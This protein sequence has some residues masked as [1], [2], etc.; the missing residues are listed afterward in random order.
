MTPARIVQLLR[1]GSAAMREEADRLGFRINIVGPAVDGM[2]LD[3]I[4]KMWEADN[5]L[6]E[7]VDT[8]SIHAYSRFST[9]QCN[10]TNKRCIRR[11]QLI[12]DFL[13]SHGGEHVHLASTEG[14]IAGTQGTCRG[15]QVHT[16][17]GQ[18]A[19]NEEALEWI[20]ANP[21]L[22]FDFWVTYHA[23]DG[24]RPYGYPC[25]AGVYDNAF[26]KSRLG[27][28]RADLSMKP[29]GARYRQLAASW[30]PDDPPA[31]DPPVE[32]PPVEDPPVEDPPVEDPPV[33]DPPD[34]TVGPVIDRT[35]G[36]HF[37]NHTGGARV[38][39]IFNGLTSQIG[40][41]SAQKNYS[42][43][44]YA[45][46]DLASPSTIALAIVYGPND[47]G[48]VSNDNRTTVMLQL[49]ASDGAPPATDM[50]ARTQGVAL[51]EVSFTDTADESVG[52]EIAS[53]DAVNEYDNVWVVMTTGSNKG[54]RM[55]EIEFRRW[56]E[57]AGAQATARRP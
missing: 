26:W 54:H 40:G 4:V 50:E 19:L 55:T 5:R 13:D 39:G 32:D 47:I 27:V 56:T 21:G 6:F 16:E 44:S 51:G 10:V 35:L 15:P 28:V 43:M 38:A 33:D 3:Y 12:R 52:R 30:Y 17:E 36:T 7:Y 2:D 24:T 45:G 1:I 29:W 42:T 41:Q 49:R 48:Y 46:T 18:S 34:P 20:R 31:D 22:D 11:T 37:G 9:L 8:L 25:D 57:D 23:I 14:A 53:S